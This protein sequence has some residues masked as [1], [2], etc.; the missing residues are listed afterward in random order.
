MQTE[1]VT[2]LRAGTVTDPYSSTATLAWELDEG[3]DW[4]TEPSSADL[5]TLAPAEP[6]PS[7]EPVQDAR[8]AVVSGYTLYLPTTADVNAQDRFVVRGG[9]YDV[10]GDPALWLSAGLVVQVGRVAG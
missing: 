5:T 1:T 8:N 7:D 6:R 4:T 2:R 9:T 10:L 3:Q